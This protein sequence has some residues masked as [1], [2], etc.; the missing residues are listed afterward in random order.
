MCARPTIRRRF[1]RGRVALQL[2][3]NV[4]G[5]ISLSPRPR[6]SLR[7]SQ[8]NMPNKAAGLLAFPLLKGGVTASGQRPDTCGGR[9]ARYL[10][11]LFSF[12]FP[13]ERSESRDRVGGNGEPIA[14]LLRSAASAWNGHI[15]RSPAAIPDRRA[16]SATSGKQW[17]GGA[18]A[19]G[20]VSILNVETV[21]MGSSDRR[22]LFRSTQRV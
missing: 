4:R 5:S 3:G 7:G 11:S 6:H 22:R 21:S 19:P 8:P 10:T 16:P 15:P 9:C 17:R 2:S 1:A 13:A 20:L 12:Y 18:K 14:P